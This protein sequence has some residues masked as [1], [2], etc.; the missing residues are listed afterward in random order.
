LPFESSEEELDEATNRIAKVKKLVTVKVD[1]EFPDLS[2]FKW[3]DLEFYY[4]A[5]I[6]YA[7][8]NCLI[9]K[10]EIERYHSIMGLFPI[11]YLE[12]GYGN[13]S[14]FALELIHNNFKKRCSSYI[15]PVREQDLELFL[16]T[17]QVNRVCD[18]IMSLMSRSISAYKELLICHRTCIEKSYKSIEQLK[19][20]EIIHRSNDSYKAAS[21]VTTLVI[22]LCSS[23]DLSTKLIQYINSIN[24]SKFVYKAARDTHYHEVR[25]IKS[26]FLTEELLKSIV[27]LQQS[28][29]EI[30]E[31]IQFRNDLIHSTS[32]LELEKIYV[33]I[34]T[35]EINGLPLYYSA[36]Y[37]RDCLDNGQ[38]IRFLG[39][40]YFVE[41]RLDIEVK[42]LSWITTVR[43]TLSC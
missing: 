36:Q 10:K 23:L 1:S 35:D 26:K 28:N 12:C 39:R 34:E 43:L 8:L 17:N 4:I 19:S 5:H 29:I 30:P 22:S 33:G 31:I 32:A 7:F 40:D 38:P 37:A 24:P 13:G 14:K 2:D 16:I 21:A 25:K 11:G 6:D 41:E 9:N 27:E 18:D 20:K 42:T 3:D 15:S